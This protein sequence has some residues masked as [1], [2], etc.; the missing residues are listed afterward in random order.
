MGGFLRKK[1]VHLFLIAA[2]ALIAY[3]NTFNVPFVF[4]DIPNIVEN[5]LLKDPKFLLNPWGHELSRGNPAFQGR[6][7]GFLSLALNLWAGGE[8]VRGFHAVNLA[9]HILAAFFL[10]FLVLKTFESPFLEGSALRKDSAFIAL[11]SALLFVSHPVQTQAVTYIVQ[12][13][14]S[15]CAAFYFASLFFY[16]KSRLSGKGG[17]SGLYYALCLVFALLAMKTKEIAITLPLAIALYE[18]LFLKESPK[19]RA[20]ILAPVFVTIFVIPLTMASAGNPIQGISDSLGGIS[21]LQTEMPRWSYLITQFTVVARYIRLLFLPAGQNLDY[22]HPVFDSFT[23]PQVVLSLFFVLSVFLLAVYLIPR[24]LRTEPAL[25]LAS[26]GT[27]WFFIALMPE[28]SI[29]PIADVI[30]E[31]RVY[32][33][34]GGAFIA[35][36]ALALFFAYRFGGRLKAPAAP[37]LA[38]LSMA[39]VLLS[40]LTFLRNGVWRSERSLWEDTVLKSPMKARPHNNHG[41]ALEKDGLYH[42]AIEEYMTAM[43]LDPYY[44]EAHASLASAYGR[45]GRLDESIE[46]FKAAMQRFPEN[47][48]LYYGLGIAYAKKGMLLDAANALE[49]AVNIRPRYPAAIEALATVYEKMGLYD[50]AEDT[51]MLLK[52]VF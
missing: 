36:S 48:R 50:L 47:E 35:V 46:A 41:V 2:V 32:L 19:K 22:D 27:I 24:S 45:L 23:S 6:F 39:V 14:A 17:S 30:Y 52:Q 29:I 1:T 44:F 7:V 16:A 11:F 43:R 13:V 9:I 37:A 40:A 8:D 38:L 31:H 34:S 4:D 28:S 25:R 3:S 20:L 33:P 21:R 42:E 10:F 15:L 12:R 49:Y 51:R 26:F 18:F 5:P